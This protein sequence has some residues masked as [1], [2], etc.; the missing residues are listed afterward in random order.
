MDIIVGAGGKRLLEAPQQVWTNEDTIPAAIFAG[1]TM[2]I[3]EDGEDGEGGFELLYLDF[4]SSKF[5]TKEIA[6]AS[7]PLFASLVLL[8]MREL[9]NLERT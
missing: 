3:M 6:K 8:H 4:K 9:I 7:A 5:L 2:L 1:K